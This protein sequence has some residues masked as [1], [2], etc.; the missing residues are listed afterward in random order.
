MGGK[1][2]TSGK[3]RFWVVTDKPEPTSVRTTTQ[4]LTSTPRQTTSTTT[5][6]STT[7]RTTTTRPT[8]T[9]RPT[10]TTT[11]TQK[12]VTTTRREFPRRI[13]IEQIPVHEY[14]Y[15]QEDY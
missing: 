3:K 15:E 13:A 8:T 12:P 1:K 5:T 6:R 10:T 7:R 9:R 14:Q 2:G 11:T 4:R